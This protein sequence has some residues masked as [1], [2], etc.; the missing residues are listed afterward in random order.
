[1]NLVE[2]EPASGKAGGVMSNLTALGPDILA[3]RE[4]LAIF[5]STGKAKN[6]T[7]VQ[8]TNEQVKCLS[9]KDVEKCFKRYETRG[10]KDN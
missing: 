9:D 2:A 8:M 1:M 5:V 7:G 6:A 10:L 4:Q 3:Q